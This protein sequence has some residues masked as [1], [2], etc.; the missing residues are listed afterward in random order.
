[1]SSYGLPPPDKFYKYKSTNTDEALGRIRAT[2]M[3]GD[4]YFPPASQLNDPF[5]L[6]PVFSLDAPEEIQHSDFVRMSKKFAPT[7]SD[8]QHQ[9]EADRM[10]SDSLSP[11][12]IQTTASIIQLFYSRYLTQ[13]VGV[14]CVTAKPTNL[15][16]WAHYADSH[17]GICL[18]FD[19]ATDVLAQAQRVTYSAERI[20][21]NP[22]LDTNNEMLVKGL[23]TKSD[24]W[25][26]EDEWRAFRNS[27]GPG[28]VKIPPA[29]VTGIIVGA[30]APRK[31]VVWALDMARERGNLKVR[32]ANVS[33]KK[34]ELELR[35]AIG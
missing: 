17:K 26:Y 23:L 8:V 32:R 22:Y 7:L 12:N 5:E 9:A 1:M 19:G 25:S 34:F 18:E 6:H 33:G 4:L 16:M 21:I 30:L 24:H 10:L 27:E 2:V 14:F 29:A 28:I 11:E 35:K 3:N 15:L 13:N 20:P 31:I